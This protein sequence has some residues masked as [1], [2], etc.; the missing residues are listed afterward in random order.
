MKK[1]KVGII[2]SSVAAIAV[3][4]SMV[5][6]STFALFT[7][8]DKVNIAVTSGKV[9]VVA[10]LKE[11][12]VQTKQK[13][14]TWETATNTYGGSVTVEGKLV[15]LNNIVPGDAVKFDLEVVNNSTV[16]VNFKTILTAQDDN[17]LFGG[18]D[19][20]VTSET[21]NKGIATSANAA[22][23]TP[24]P[25]ATE[26]TKSVATV[27]VEIEL[28]EEA[29]NLY[30]GKQ[31]TV[32][33]AI[34]AIQGNVDKINNQV[35]LRTATADGTV[36]E[37][38]DSIKAAVDKLTA[39]EV[40]SAEIIVHGTVPSGAG[41]AV[42]ENG[43]NLTYLQP[44]VKKLTI[45]G[46]GLDA[47]INGGINLSALTSAA[48]GTSVVVSNIEFVNDSPAANEIIVL[49][50]QHNLLKLENCVFH[51]HVRINGGTAG[52]ADEIMVDGCRFYKP[53]NT[54]SY[55][56][57]PQTSSVEKVTIKN[58][59]IYGFNR[60]INAHTVNADVEMLNNT[61]NLAVDETKPTKCVPALQISVAKSALISGNEV[62]TEN[63]YGLRVHEYFLANGGTNECKITVKDN[64][65]NVKYLLNNETVGATA[66]K[67]DD[68]KPYSNA[69]ITWSNNISNNNQW[70]GLD[71]IEGGVIEL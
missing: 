5:V 61:V 19:I 32:V 47:K 43:Y 67:L 23:W 46:E 65:F 10:N 64:T 27:T 22:E 41:T 49:S 26:S 2:A 38:V 53:V 21:T 36:T 66:D 17:G 12:T 37:T 42:N 7:G 56:V 63:G 69:N 48:E 58:C 62:F 3:C 9:E 45:K 34:E 31:C 52:N 13:G 4:S 28:P 40:E 55:A 30:K 68:G 29:G 8:E 54:S 11:G 20:K 15:K 51:T 14:E 1:K 6:G 25:A 50:S 33:Y 60:G 59:L 18:L 57:M 44:K 24:L 35:E 70:L 16:M 39:T 71:D